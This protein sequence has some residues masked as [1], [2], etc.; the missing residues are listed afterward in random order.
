MPARSTSLLW[1]A[2]CC[3]LAV[4]FSWPLPLHL[5]THLTGAP[6][7]DTGVYV[8]NLWVFRHEVLQQHLPLQT[9]TVLSLAPPVDLTLH[10]YTLF[11]DALAFPLIGTLG[12]IRTFN[13]VYLA[14]MALSAWAMA[15]LAYTLCGRSW[16]A[17]LAG[18]AFGFSP[19]MLARSTGHF[20]L[21]AAAPLP[22]M[23]LVL[24]RGEGKGR[25][26][27][28]VALGALLAWAAFCDIYYA[29][30]GA[31]LV[32]AY[33]LAA[34]ITISRAPYDSRLAFAQRVSRGLVLVAATFVLLVAVHG[35]LVE[36]AGLRISMRSLYTPMLVLTVLAIVA[37]LLRWRPRIEWRYRFVSQHPWL[38]ALMVVTA[39][40]LLSPVLV[41]Y[42]G[43]LLSGES[44]SPDI[45][46]RSSPPGVDL[47]AFVMPNPSSA[48]FGAPFKAWIEA[49]RVDGF[50]ELTGAMPL[51]ALGCI[52]LAAALGW[53]PERRRWLGFTAFFALLS[54]GPFVHVGGINT[55]IPGPWALL[56][57]VPI[58]GLAR[59]PSRFVVLVSLLVAVLFA[60]ALTALTTR[61]PAR[62]RLLLGVVTALLLFELSPVPRTLYS[63]AIP[64]VFTTIAADPQTD[65]RVLSLPFGL[66]DGTSSLGNFNPLTQ[67]YQTAHGKRL[68]GGYLSRLTPQQKEWHRRFPVLD[69]LFT[70]SADPAARL[71]E[72]QRSLAYAARDRFLGGLRLAYVVTEDAQT[73]PAL[74]AFAEDLLRLEK[75][76]SADGFTLYVPKAPAGPASTPAR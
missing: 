12:L 41:A 48:L 33:V 56:R 51:V 69:A 19:V 43:R 63:A 34:A 32:G 26:R 8:W 67:Y 31:L 72:Q 6:S 21:V 22:L 61:W 4:A 37:A 15:R 71:T 10:N 11:M 65:I 60:L 49:Q 20:S 64:S 47:L 5:G 30:Y 75:V 62:R 28:A 55:Y 23:L 1:L 39:A 13:L 53:R 66:R 42:G 18:V 68:V 54:L 50:A 2:L 45:Y 9:G 70:L 35:G 38:A 58:V 59:S 36:I 16:E 74:R 27:D 3:G 46:W 24:V 7:G 73:T 14:M 44:A 29:V 40:V 57:Y 52:A 25:P 17:W 76:M